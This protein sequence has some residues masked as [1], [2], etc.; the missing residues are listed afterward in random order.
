MTQNRRWPGY[1]VAVCGIDGSGKTTQ[2]QQV[3]TTLAERGETVLTR[4]PT[5]RYRK[6]P[7]VRKM[8]DLEVDDPVVLAELALLAAFDRARHFR[9][10]VLPALNR[11]AA[12]VTDRY[13][14]SSYTYFLARG[15]TDLDWLKRVNR[16][17][18]RPDLTLFMDVPPVVAAKR[19]IE[20]DGSSNKREE[21]DVERMTAV[22]EAFRTQ[23]WDDKPSLHI[24]DATLPLEAVTETVLDLVKRNDPR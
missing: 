21:L 9:E 11:G 14:Y 4:Q 1:F 10:I 7:M 15:L 8:F 17:L 5:D 24:I 12:V 16:G 2:I 19:I 20:R 23:P 18:P 6:D 13:V 22:R 3:E